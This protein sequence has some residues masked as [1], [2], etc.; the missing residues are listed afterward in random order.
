MKKCKKELRA[1]KRGKTTFSFFAAIHSAELFREERLLSGQ[2]WSLRFPGGRFFPLHAP[3]CFFEED[4]AQSDP[5]LFSISSCFHLNIGFCSF[6]LVVRRFPDAFI[7]LRFY[8]LLFVFLMCCFSDL[9]LIFCRN[10]IIVYTCLKKHKTG[11]CANADT[12][13][14]EHRSCEKNGAVA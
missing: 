6:F 3:L 7:L 14:A 11:R 10:G 12:L 1:E 9:R 5:R 4:P 2:I 8:L 13:V